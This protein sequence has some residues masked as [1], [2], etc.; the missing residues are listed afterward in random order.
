MNTVSGSNQSA[1]WR[2]QTRMQ[3]TPKTSVFVTISGLTPTDQF[4]PIMLLLPPSPHYFQNIQNYFL[5]HPWLSLMLSFNL[6]DIKQLCK[7]LWET[8]C[9]Q[10]WPFLSCTWPHC[11]VLTATS[12]RLRT[13]LSHLPF[14]CIFVW[15][16]HIPVMWLSLCIHRVPIW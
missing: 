2:M 8:P 10:H 15:I 9:S 13:A 11:Q 6:G 5:F 12:P 16:L 14:Y 4:L 1:E 3:A 7:L